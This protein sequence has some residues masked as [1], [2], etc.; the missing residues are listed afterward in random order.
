[1][2]EITHN[3]VFSSDLLLMPEVISMKILLFPLLLCSTDAPL[4]TITLVDLI[5]TF[6]YLGETTLLNLKGNICAL[7]TLLLLTQIS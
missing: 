6:S 7:S 3:V 4:D 2:T 1:M 5:R